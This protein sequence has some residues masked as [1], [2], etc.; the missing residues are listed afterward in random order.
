[1]KQQP[2]P[3]DCPDRAAG[4]GATCEEWQKYVKERNADYEQRKEYH[5]L[6]EMFFDAKVK[7]IR[8]A[9]QRRRK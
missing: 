7:V 6:N 8:K 9:F 1:M 2:C 3:K 5:E 4:C